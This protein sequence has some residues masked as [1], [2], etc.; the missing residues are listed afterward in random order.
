MA[1]IRTS[2]EVLYFNIPILLCVLFKVNDKPPQAF[3]EV[4]SEIVAEPNMYYQI[5][6]V[7]PELAHFDTL[8]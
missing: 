7:N 3:G 6:N 1:A 2:N 4:W 8:K 5:K